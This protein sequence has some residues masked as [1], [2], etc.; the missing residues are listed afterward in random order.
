MNRLVAYLDESGEEGFQFTTLPQ[1]SSSEWF[2]LSAVVHDLIDTQTIIDH[3]EKFKTQTGKNT[4]WHFHFNKQKHDT[5]V[6]FL[7]HMAKLPVS[8]LSVIVHK[9]SIEKPENFK[10]PY[11]LYFYAAKILF[12]RLSWLARDRQSIVRPILSGRR[13][14]TL[15]DLN[16]YLA[17][18]REPKTRDLEMRNHSIHWPSL[19]ME[20]AEILPNKKLR[21]L[22]LADGVAS[23]VAKAIERSKYGHTEHRYAK[24]LKPITLQTNGS[25]LGYGLKF[26]PRLSPD[27]RTRKELQWL[28]RF[29]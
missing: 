28:S 15:T 11:Y 6:G 9:P 10:R 21:C 14:L 5:R 16:N 13:G 18:L 27:I 20:G 12:E 25:Y 29:E 4:D 1:K 23:G 2:I 3:Y 19:N 26:F 7:E 24:I 17:V 22:Q 8:S